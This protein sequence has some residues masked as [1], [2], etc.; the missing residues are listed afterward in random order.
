MS[1]LLLL[2]SEPTTPTQRKRFAFKLTITLKT[3]IDYSVKVCGGEKSKAVTLKMSTSPSPCDIKTNTATES[4]T[5]FNIVLFL[6]EFVAN[7]IQPPIDEHDDI[8]Y[9]WETGK[10]G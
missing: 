10:H 7:T 5:S 3:P 8:F 1:V 6:V 2:Q 9:H 4:S